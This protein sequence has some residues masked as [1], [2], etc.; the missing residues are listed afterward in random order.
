MDILFKFLILFAPVPVTWFVYRFLQKK[1]SDNND[2]QANLAGSFR[3]RVIGVIASY[4]AVFGLVVFS[5]YPSF[6]GFELKN[7]TEKWEFVIK[8]QLSADSISSVIERKGY[9]FAKNKGNGVKTIKGFYD[10]Y[11]GISLADE[12]WTADGYMDNDTFYIPIKLPNVRANVVGLGAWNRDEGRAELK[13]F[14]LFQENKQFDPVYGVMSLERRYPWL[15]L[16]LMPVMPLVILFPLSKVGTLIHN[17]IDADF[18]LPVWDGSIKGKLGGASAAYIICFSVGYL[19]FF[20]GVPETLSKEIEKQNKVS[21]LYQGEWYYRLFHAGSD[22]AVEYTGQIEF[23]VEQFKV[24]AKGRMTKTWL[25]DST[26]YNCYTT[27]SINKT[28]M[29]QRNDFEPEYHW[30]GES[31]MLVG[32]T[33]ITVYKFVGANNENKGVLFSTVFDSSSKESRWSYY[34]LSD[35][36]PDK[37]FINNGFIEAFRPTENNYGGEC[38]QLAL[39]FENS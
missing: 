33:L 10:R 37:W 23:S 9:F 24:N 32:N 26:E 36:R 17:F 34:D 1:G 14:S 12:R 8:Y 35:W 5:F 27:A 20:E 19:I 16:L 6:L 31:T 25:S 18:K 4:L 7:E 38:K 39:H 2:L 30:I 15:L 21:N 11:D 13:V 3:I 29:A 22:G 28:K